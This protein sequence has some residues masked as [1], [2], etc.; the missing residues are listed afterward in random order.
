MKGRF[1][2]DC[3]G[4]FICEAVNTEHRSPLWQ[5]PGTYLFLKAHH[6]LIC[7]FHLSFN[8]LSEEPAVRSALRKQAEQ[9]LQIA[10]L[11]LR[12]KVDLKDLGEALRE[13]RSHKVFPAQR[14][15]NK[16]TNTH[17]ELDETGSTEPTDPF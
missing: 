1:W 14:S 8:Y 11:K 15:K 2:I 16:K 7:M 12:D 5:R 6:I 17:R 13:S 3:F 4:L 10:V 9:R